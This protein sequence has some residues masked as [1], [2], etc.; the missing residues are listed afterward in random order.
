VQHRLVLRQAERDDYM[1]FDV[2]ARSLPKTLPPGRG[3]WTDGLVELQ[4]ALLADDPSGTAQATAVGRLATKLRDRWAGVPGARLAH[5]IDPLPRSIS[6]ADAE[7]LRRGHRPEGAA[8]ATLA[9]GGDELQPVDVD[10]DTSPPTFVVAGP[11]RSGR[12]TALA[13]VA[14]SLGRP[15]VVIAPRPSPLR[16]LD[17]DLLALYTSADEA[18]AQLGDLLDEAGRAVAVLVDDAELVSEGPLAGLLQQ[19][20]RQARDHDIVVVAA[21]TIDDLMLLR[22]RGWLADARR[23]RHGLL[24][25]PGSSMDGEAFDVKLPRSLSGGWPAG[26]GLLIERGTTATVQV[27]ELR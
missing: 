14:T 12:S 9:V 26:R 22:Y 24:L 19:V 16:D 3:F 8:V 23:S 6:L 25:C 10:L 21:A 18:A 5:R 1:W 4:V 2:P 27:V 20:V 17:V 11:P 7:A 13:A 15:I